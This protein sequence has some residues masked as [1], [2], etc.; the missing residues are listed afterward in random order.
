MK[1]QLA[2]VLSTVGTVALAQSP[3]ERDLLAEFDVSRLPIK[4]SW[5][6]S[7]EGLRVQPGAASRTLLATDIPDRYELTVELTRTSGSD[8]VAV[9]LPVGQVSPALELSAWQGVA[10][11]MS[12]VDGLP[13]KS[14]RNPTAVKPGALTNGERH[15][16][17]IAVDASAAPI[18]VAVKLD[19]RSLFAWK[20]EM[21]RLQQNLGLNLP[22]PRAIGLASQQSEVIFHRVVLKAA[23]ESKE[24]SNVPGQVTKK[25]MPK[26]GPEKP[27]PSDLNSTVSG[28]A[29]LQSLENFNDAQFEA[30][31]EDGSQVLRSRPSAGTGDRGAWL[32]GATFSEGTI[33]VNLKGTAQPQCSFL[34]VAFNGVDGKTYES[35]YFRPFNFGSSDPVRRSHAVQYMS[36]PDWPWDRL[37][38]ERNGEFEA[39]AKPEPQPTEWFRAK[40]EVRNG[41]IRVFVNEASSPCLDVASLANG[42][43]DKV[44]LWFNGTA[45]FANLKIQAD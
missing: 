44:G 19:G 28:M 15:K 10:H 45:S 12:R 35:V 11:G 21:R 40:I 41:R 20:G 38:R 33:E 9:I 31:V 18:T 34:G 14:D 27:S 24:S 17:E 7:D 26:A 23:Q 30:V 3:S 29:L 4:G 39:A 13:V 2:I 8:S 42:R 6:L 32:K 22:V 1:L 5:T 16:L 36:H 25:G 43:G 37:R